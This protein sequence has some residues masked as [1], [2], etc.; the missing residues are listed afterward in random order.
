[1]SG[2]PLLIRGKWTR[3]QENEQFYSIGDG[4]KKGTVGIQSTIP[5]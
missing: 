1:M 3:G 2:R 5:Y 4:A